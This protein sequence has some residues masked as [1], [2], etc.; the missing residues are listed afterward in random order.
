MAIYLN[1]F[2]G[3]DEEENKQPKKKKDRPNKVI[4]E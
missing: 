1:L 4:T 3:E 2:G